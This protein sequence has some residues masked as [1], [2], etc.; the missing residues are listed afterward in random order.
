MEERIRGAMA[1]RDLS[2]RNVFTGIGALGLALMASPRLAR[3]AGYPNMIGEVGTTRALPGETLMD[4]MRRT[5][6]GYVEIVVANPAVDT[7]IPNPEAD[8]VLPTAHIL[9][10]APREG[11]VL[12]LPEQRLYYFQP[13]GSPIRSFP[14]GIGSEGNHTPL[15]RTSIVRKQKNPTWYIPKSIL[16]EE[17]GRKP[18]VP[19]GPDNPL[20]KH[21]LYLKWPAYLIHGTNLP[22]AIGRR[23]SH[24]CINMYPESV[25]YLFDRVPIGTSVTVVNQPAKVA[26]VDGQLLLQTHL[27]GK[28]ADELEETGKFEP[29]PIPNLEALVTKAA[30]DMKDRV[31]W[32]A[33]KTAEEKRN[34][35]P[36]RII[37]DQAA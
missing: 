26:M 18:V 35:I 2:R 34:G 24:G 16:K 19:P 37:K 17:P 4:V 3:A 23:A 9:P 5:N 10:D 27:T 30:G 22:D 29:E 32:D 28:Q 15:G 14:I 20:G 7:W 36:V 8:I 13:G 11:L 12:N 1:H 6:L 21:A 33:V 25:E 31:D